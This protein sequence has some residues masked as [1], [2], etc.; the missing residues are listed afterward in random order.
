MHRCRP[1][2]S[3]MCRRHGGNFK[4]QF[5]A[6]CCL[7]KPS[8]GHTRLARVAHTAP[9]PNPRVAHTCTRRVSHVCPTRVRFNLT[10]LRGRGIGRHGHRGVVECFCGGAGGSDSEAGHGLGVER[11]SALRAS[12]VSGSTSAIGGRSECRECGGALQGGV[13]RRLSGEGSN[14]GNTGRRGRRQNRGPGAAIFLE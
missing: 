9:Q 14:S 3:H 5:T 8:R 13:T 10:R 12:N 11:E 7:E 1:R 6:F 4:T 2:I